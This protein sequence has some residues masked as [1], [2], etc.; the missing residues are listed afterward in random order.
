M[1]KIQALKKIR[2]FIEQSSDLDFNQRLAMLRIIQDVE[3][4]VN[5]QK[6]NL[7]TILLRLRYG[8]KQ[9]V[10]YEWARVISVP[11]EVDMMCGLVEEPVPRGY[12]IR[13][14]DY[15]R[16]E[17]LMKSVEKIEREAAKPIG[18]KLVVL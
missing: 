11:G 2:K 17:R 16:P 14:G 13:G 9:S 8:V 12:T 1:N 6:D 18:R 3:G 5:R 10:P 7:D 4:G 15:K